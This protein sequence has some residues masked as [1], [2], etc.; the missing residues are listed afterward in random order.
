MTDD[1]RQI[2]DPP[3][4][5]ATVGAALWA[6]VHEAGD[7]RGSVEPLLMLCEKLDERDD[8]RAS[9][10]ASGDWRDRVA[11]RALDQQIAD[12]LER[13]GIRS[14]LPLRESHADDWTVRLAR[15]RSSGGLT[16]ELTE[17]EFEASQQRASASLSL[18]EAPNGS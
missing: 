3:R 5:L 1:S 2:P 16:Y 10:A 12:G 14:L 4:K 9:V 7:V 6:D 13:L 8:L 17:E 11:L 15:L 18:D